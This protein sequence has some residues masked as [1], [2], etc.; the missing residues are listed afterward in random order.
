MVVAP[1]S[2][3]LAAADMTRQV[4]S[5]EIGA[6]IEAHADFVWRSLR[7]FGVPESVTD[8]AT[9]R[10]FIIAQA[11][12]PRISAGRERGFLFS[13]AMNVAAHARRAAA[14][15]REVD[16]EPLADL[17]DPGPLP[18]AELEERRARALLDEVLDAMPVDLRT[19][20]VLFELE[21]MS[22]AEIADVLAIPSGTVAS[23]LRRAREAFHKIAQRV[24]SRVERCNVDAN[25]EPNRGAALP[26]CEEEVSE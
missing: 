12:L 17:V 4:T 16:D 15:R 1:D 20:F 8:D 26:S 18:D 14:R 9:Q 21:E 24:R 6:L 23:R 25:A 2:P 11:K 19:V 3:P 7:R 5:I 10:V 13:V 22:M